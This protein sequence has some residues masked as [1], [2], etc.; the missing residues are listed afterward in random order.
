MKNRVLI[1]DDNPMDIELVAAILTGLNIEYIS[2]ANGYEALD[3]LAQEAISFIVLDLQMP[4]IS[5]LQLLKRLKG[6][7][8]YASIPVMVMSG[9]NQPKDVKV[10]IGLGANDYTVKP[11]DIDVFENKIGSYILYQD[12]DWARYDIPSDKNAEV[13]IS[14]SASIMSISEIGLQIKSSAHYEKSSII[15]VHNGFLKENLGIADLKILVDS[16]IQQDDHYI[17]N[18]RYVAVTEA[19]RKQIR[20]YCRKIWVNDKEAV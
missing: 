18:C 1:I 20:L 11:L 15:N 13:D 12:E 19:Q 2:A 16:A 6:N 7:K 8:D 5:G 4:Q 17:Y 9:R 10:A 14:C 3:I